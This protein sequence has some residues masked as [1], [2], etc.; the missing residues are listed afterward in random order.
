MK[1]TNA[2]VIA[3]D[4]KHFDSLEDYQKAVVAD[5]IGCPGSMEC[6]LIPC[7]ECRIRWLEQEWEG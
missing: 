2:Q 4:L 3:H 1:P 7:I 6:G 5:Y